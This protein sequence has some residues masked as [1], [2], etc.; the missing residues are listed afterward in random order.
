MPNK[1][2]T[3]WMIKKALECCIISDC[4]NCPMGHRATGTYN[5]HCGTDLMKNAFNLINRLQ[6]ENNLLRKTNKQLNNSIDFVKVKDVAEFKAENERLKLLNE[7]LKS[8]YKNGNK[9]L[10]DYLSDLVGNQ[11]DTIDKQEAEI[12]RLKPFEDKIAEFKS[13]IRVEDMLVFASSLG[14]WLEFMQKTKTEAYKEFAE[15]AEN[16]ILPMLTTATA[17]E[18]ETVCFC[19]DKIKN[20]LKELVG[21]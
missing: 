3:D 7:R 16:K 1:L 13:H 19:L 18:K 10:N 9:S 14:E 2:L 6:E 20:L 4:P 8:G 17:E 21:E 15:K 5:E 11:K 12:E